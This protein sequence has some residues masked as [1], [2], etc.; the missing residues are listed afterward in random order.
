M[1][2]VVAY[3]IY[4]ECCEGKLRAGEW[5]IPKPVT[6]HRFR[7]KLFSQMLAYSPRNRKYPGDENFRTSTQEHVNRRKSSVP[8]PSVSAR[9]AGTSVS[10]STS[11][12]ASGITMEDFNNANARLCGNLTPLYC[13]LTSVA[14]LPNNRTRIC[15]VCG[16]GTS[17]I[18][19]KCTNPVNK[20][21]GV[22]LHKHSRDGNV[23]C[24]F[25]YHN[26]EF[27]G[28]AKNDYWLTGKRKRDWR[29][30]PSIEDRSEHGRFVRLLHER[31]RPLSAPPRA[32][33]RQQA[34]LPPLPPPAAQRD[35]TPVPTATASSPEA[36][37][38]EI[39]RGARSCVV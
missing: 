36:A 35:N 7:E 3:D 12:V 8:M 13:H 15:A 14:T 2:T 27:F 38:P 6:F 33:S 29:G 20:E 22:P 37:T 19:L 16:G 1:A 24:F 28:L 11:S 17:Q 32:A 30:M 18:C 26:T 9:R 23:P 39:R 31:G 34:P 21:I 4:L 10:S 25:H 5:Y